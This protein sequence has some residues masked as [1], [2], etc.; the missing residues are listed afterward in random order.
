MRIETFYVTPK[1]RGAIDYKAPVTC[2]LPDRS[3]EIDPDRKFPAMVVLPGGG[4][5]FT[6]DTEAEPIALRFLSAG[7]AVFVLRYSVAP[8]TYPQALCEAAQTIA[9]VRARAEEFCID[10]HKVAVCG[11]SAGGHLTASISN[12]YGSEDVLSVLGGK[13]EDYRP[14]AHVL[15][16]P[17]ISFTRPHLG[18][19]QNLLG[20]DFSE[21]RA[22]ALSMEKHVT[23]NTPPAF[24]WSTTNDR[25]VPV[26][27]TYLYA[28]AL[29]EHGVPSEVHV[30]PDGVHGL[31]LANWVSNKTEKKHN[32]IASAWIGE[33]IRWLYD[34][35]AIGK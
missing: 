23:E 13:A 12:L 7:F 1:T 2:Y 6:S 24:L 29:A 31:S 25:S 20:A 19:F 8:A 14:D 5:H 16:Y 3:P 32:P 9:T 18:S 30:Y 27:N 10:P 33:A 22:L 15:S 17:V 35:L 11:F 34:V 4:Y 21:E 26:Q 28:L